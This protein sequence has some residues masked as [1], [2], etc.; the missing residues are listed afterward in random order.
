[1]IKDVSAALLKAKHFA[2]KQ[3][4]HSAALIYAAI[5]EQWPENQEALNAFSAIMLD[6]SKEFSSA[7]QVPTKEAPTQTQLEQLITLYQQGQLPEALRQV[8]ALLEQFPDTPVLYLIM[9]RIAFDRGEL[10]LAVESYQRATDLDPYYA[11]AHNDLGVYFSRWANM[12]P[13]WRL[14]KRWLR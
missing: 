9:G 11:D 3:D 2:E 13:Q 7:P 1:M 10:T 4:L 12:K 6:P 14:W 5:L 8:E